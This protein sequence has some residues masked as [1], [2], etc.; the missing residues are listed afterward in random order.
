[1]PS[2]MVT[3]PKATSGGAIS[4]TEFAATISMPMP[5]IGQHRAGLR[6]PQDP[7]ERRVDRPRRVHRDRRRLEEPLARRRLD[8]G[9]QLLVRREAIE[10]LVVHFGLDPRQPRPAAVFDQG[11]D[12]PDDPA[13]DR[14]HHGGDREALDGLPPH[15]HRA[16]LR[17][18]PETHVAGVSVVFGEEVRRIVPDLRMLRQEART[19]QDTAAGSRGSRAGS[20]RGEEFAEVPADTASGSLPAPAACRPRSPWPLTSKTRLGPPRPAWPGR[21]S[22]AGPRRGSARDRQVR[23]TRTVRLRRIDI[24]LSASLLRAV[25]KGVNTRG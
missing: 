12:Q 22:G 3:A 25:G 9:Q 5:R 14:E 15:L 18:L 16:L 19:E 10:Q 11:L 13:A 1:M 23:E 21:R 6:R 7:P 24:N 17:R 2:A 8:V 20:D 4:S